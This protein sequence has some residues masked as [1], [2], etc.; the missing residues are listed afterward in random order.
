MF[1]DL[2]GRFN[3]CCMCLCCIAL[4]Y[5]VSH[6]HAERFRKRS[7]QQ[8]ARKLQKPASR[9]NKQQ[10]LV[11]VLWVALIITKGRIST[12]CTDPVLDIKTT[13][14]KITIC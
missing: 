9:D 7:R 6:T 14:I 8:K 5:C 4:C 11:G 3:M 13:T 12:S 10:L 2:G 1:A